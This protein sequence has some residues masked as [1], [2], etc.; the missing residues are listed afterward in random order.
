VEPSEA[1]APWSGVGVQIARCY[2]KLIAAGRFVRSSSSAGG[3][4]NTVREAR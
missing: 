3:V 2:E 1:A 4:R